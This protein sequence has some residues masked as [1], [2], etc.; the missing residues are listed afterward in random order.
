M[1][2]RGLSPRTAS[3]LLMAAA[4]AFALWAGS[5]FFDLA[6]DMREGDTHRVDH[7]ILMW[8]ETHRTPTLTHIFYSITALGSSAVLTILTLGTCVAML[9]AGERRFAWTLLV[10]MAGTPILSQAMKR[11]Y[12]RERPDIVPHLEIVSDPSFPSGHTVSSIAFFVTIALLAAAYTP[13]RLLRGFLVGY[14]L[15]IAALVALSRV[16]L[17]VHYPSDVAGG[18]LLGI[19]WS[20]MCVVGDRLLRYRSPIDHDRR[21]SLT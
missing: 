7:A 12:A 16:Y 14:A 9:L 11:I 1:K 2:Q 15:L 5:Q 3:L 17:G 4:V 6:D 13:Q 10:V 18:A 8:F 20:L 21:R 19:T